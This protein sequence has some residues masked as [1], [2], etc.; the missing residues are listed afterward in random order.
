MDGMTEGPNLAA[1][2][3]RIPA[4][5]REAAERLGPLQDVHGETAE[6]RAE[7]RRVQAENRAARWMR[8]LPVMYATAALEDLLADGEQAEAGQ[9]CRDWLGSTSTTLVLA[10]PVGTGK[11]HA[12]YAVGHAAVRRGLW[13]EA[14][15]L[16]DLLEALRPEGDKSAL[17]AV[18]SCDLLLL[19][20]LGATKVSEWAVE[21]MTSLLDHRLREQR[22]QV[23]TTNAPYQVLEDA[24]GGRFAD[25]LRFRWTV[26]T[27]LGESRRKAAW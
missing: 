8:R 24:W 14:W 15:T 19:D 3:A 18:R 1:I 26:V 16:S 11:T 27:L 4:E 10:G 9:V 20:D 5:A 22:R 12:A 13:V 6:D 23:V 25:R 21:T 2:L 7:R 17:E